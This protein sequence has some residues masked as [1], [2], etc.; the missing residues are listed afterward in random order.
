MAEMW[1]SY[2]KAEPLGCLED[3]A[4]RLRNFPVTDPDPGCFW[5]YREGIRD[6]PFDNAFSARAMSQLFKCYKSATSQSSV[7]GE[8]LIRSSLG[9]FFIVLRRFEEPRPFSRGPCLVSYPHRCP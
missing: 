6:Y 2:P 5:H 3:V 9:E 1:P 4:N 8:G 7:S